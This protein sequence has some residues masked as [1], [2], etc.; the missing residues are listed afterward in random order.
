MVMAMGPKEL[1]EGVASKKM[2]FS[3][4]TAACT[5]FLSL[6]LWCS[7]V[8]SLEL[9]GFSCAL[10]WNRWDSCSASPW[11]SWGWEKKMA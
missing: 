11:V 2:A 3:V 10:G 9:N 1:L 8:V 7:L 5:V 4:D 6:F